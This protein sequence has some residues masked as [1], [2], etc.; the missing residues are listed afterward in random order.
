MLKIAEDKVHN[1][2]RCSQPETS[3]LSHSAQVAST[4]G[5]GLRTTWIVIHLPSPFPL[6]IDFKPLAVYVVSVTEITSLCARS[7]S[8]P[9]PE[10]R[11]FCANNWRTRLITR[12]NNCSVLAELCF[13]V[14]SRSRE[15]FSIIQ[16]TKKTKKFCKIR[17]VR[18]YDSSV[19]S[20]ELSSTPLDKLAKNLITI[21]RGYS[22]VFSRFIHKK[23]ANENKS[24]SS[25]TATWIKRRRLES[26]AIFHWEKLAST[27]LPMIQQFFVQL[28]NVCLFSL[29]SPPPAIF[30]DEPNGCRQH[31]IRE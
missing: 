31:K 20:H 16:P 15:I 25:V 17:K 19:S 23:F 12:V 6:S 11:S 3:L 22:T 10:S 13:V 21:Y 7:G 1:S 5:K 30:S 9:S 4:V 8:H 24:S 27:R 28:A 2:R 18:V 14:P 29:F 26:V